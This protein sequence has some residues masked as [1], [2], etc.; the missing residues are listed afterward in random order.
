V[1]TSGGSSRVAPTK[2]YAAALLRAH[3]GCASSWARRVCFAYE[4]SSPAIHA[5]ASDAAGI[6]P[7]AA[8]LTPAGCAD[9]AAA[10][11]QHRGERAGD[12]LLPAGRLFRPVERP[13]KGSFENGWRLEIQRRVLECWSNYGYGKGRDHDRES[14]AVSNIGSSPNEPSQPRA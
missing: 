11:T 14:R 8:A 6:G 1:G 7:E 10:S 3:G 5:R 9:R 12:R 13:I 2:V 4:T